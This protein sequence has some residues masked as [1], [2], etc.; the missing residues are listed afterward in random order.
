MLTKVKIGTIIIASSLLFTGN[1]LAKDEINTEIS[2]DVTERAVN[3]AQQEIHIQL[4]DAVKFASENFVK[5]QKKALELEMDFVRL[6]ES[7][8]DVKTV[9]VVSNIND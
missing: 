7:T 3:V 4:Q 9:A 5:E 8:T 1:A 2:I 6:N